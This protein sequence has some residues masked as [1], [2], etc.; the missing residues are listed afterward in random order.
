MATNIKYQ[1]AGIQVTAGGNYVSGTPVK[2]GTALFGVPLATF[3]SG[4]QASLMVS[5][6]ADLPKTGGGGITFSLG[7]KVYWSG[8]VCTATATD[9]L[10]GVCTAAAANGDTTVEVRINGTIFTQADADAIASA[11]GGS[12]TAIG[13][14]KILGAS[15][16]GVFRANLGA[17]VAPA[18][19]D[20][21]D[22]GYHA[23]S[24]W[25]DT[26][27]GRVYYAISVADGAAVWASIPQTKTGTVA[28]ASGANN[29]TVSVGTAFNGLPVLVSLQ[30]ST[31]AIAAADAY[32]TGVVSA[33]TLTITCRVLA[34]TAQNASSDLVM[35]YSI[36]IQ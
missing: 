4:T 34:G 35:A 7:D 30:S 26:T 12:A 1:E 24:L 10:I 29:G 11:F 20:D 9:S 28:I 15:T 16:V 18:A 31:G 17:A 13:F 36:T 19:T 6:V 5:G 14:A 32:F 3:A 23:G 21:L 27:A 2:I 22:L 25:F 8:S 33:G